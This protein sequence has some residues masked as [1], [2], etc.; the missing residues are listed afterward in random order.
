MMNYP[1]AFYESQKDVPSH[2][3]G[4][5]LALGL[6]AMGV[7]ETAHGI[8]YGLKRDGTQNTMSWLLGPAIFAS[9]SVATYSYL[10][11]AKVIQ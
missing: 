6:M 1:R 2:L 4:Y 9:G 3:L 7:F 11:Y 10:K 8:Y 5:G